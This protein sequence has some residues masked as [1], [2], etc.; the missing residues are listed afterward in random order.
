MK[1][2]HIQSCA[3]A[4]LVCIFAAEIIRRMRNKQKQQKE[5]KE[6]KSEASL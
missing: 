5:Y 3:A 4:I 6:E 2:K 1:K